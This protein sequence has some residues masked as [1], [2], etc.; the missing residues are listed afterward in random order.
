M[1]VLIVTHS[2]PS[3]PLTGNGLMGLHHI[4]HLAARHTVD[5][6]SFKNTKNPNEMNDVSPW[7]NDIELVNS[8]PRWRVLSNLLIGVLR[9]APLGVFRYRSTKMTSSVNTRL[10][11]T[12]YDVVIYQGLQMCQ[13]LP[14][15]YGGA[16]V[17]VLEDPPA[18][19]SQQMLHLCPWYVRPLVWN[20]IGRQKRYESRYE[21]RFD[22]IL[23]VNQ[24]D[25]I[26]YND[27]HK[28]AMVDWVP[29][30]IDTSTF[31]P[32][33]EIPRKDGMIV[34]SG[35]MR[36]R[37]NVEGVLYFCRR[38]FPL[39]CEQV[40]SAT[41]WLVG[42]DPA[43]AIR[44]LKKD[45]RIKITGFV[46]DVRHY[47]RQAMVSVCPIQLKIGTQTKILEALACGTPVVTSSAGNH[48][49]CGVSGKDLY[50]ADDTAEFADRVVSLLRRERWSEFSLNGR[51]L[52]EDNFTWAKSVEKLEQLL[53]QLVAT[54]RRDLVC[55]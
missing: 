43:T 47:L 48:G 46:P 32:S 55:Q 42:A 53:E 8:P 4:R 41:L 17:S 40:P 11:N 44:E 49:I 50:V 6:I 10:R 36:R 33:H 29:V 19:T 15:W 28:K 45:S 37:P 52:V 21:P 23:L 3:P 35:N 13:Y 51:R 38:V 9:D 34:I 2:V 1:K 24:N 18:L 12:V 27:I 26:T 25:C 16:A 54:S 31:S 22:R 39:I 30:G 14:H 5:L 7:C 20:R